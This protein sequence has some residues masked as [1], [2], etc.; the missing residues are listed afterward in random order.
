MICHWILQGANAPQN[1]RLQ[2][3]KLNIPGATNVKWWNSGEHSSILAGYAPTEISN[4]KKQK[5]SYEQLNGVQQNPKGDIAIVM[6][7]PN[8]K[9][10]FDNTLLGHVMSRYDFK[11]PNGNGERFVSFGS[12]HRFVIAAH[13]LRIE[14]R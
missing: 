4:T 9:V 7:D 5:A 13:F 12:F 8:A 2:W 14:L 6:G 1:A 10:G 3:Y 11:G